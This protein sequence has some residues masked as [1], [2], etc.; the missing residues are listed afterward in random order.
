MAGLAEVMTKNLEAYRYYSLGVGKAQA[1]ENVEAV[2]LLRKAIQL[3]PKFAMAYARIGYAY[4]VTD[5]LPEKGRPFLEKALQLSDRLTE[6]DRLY[7]KAWHAIARQDYPDAIGTLRQII[8]QYP[9]ETEAHARLSRLLYRFEERA[10]DA[11]AVAQQGLAADPEAKDLYNVLGIYF[12]GLRRYDEA[13][14]AHQRYVQLAPAEPNAH[15]SLGMS[16]QQ[17]GRY[18]KAAAEYN[19][20]LSLDP[21]FEPAIIHLGDVY[22]QQGRY[23]EAVSQY[24]RYVQVTRSDAARAVGYG[25]IAQ[26][27]R[28]KREFRQGE[29][30]AQLE[31]NH[32]KRAIWNSLQFALDRGDTARAVNLKK[33]LF[34]NVPYPERGAKNELRSHDYY[35]GTLALRARQPDAA[36]GH[37]NQALHHLPPSSGLDLYDDCLANA[38]LELGRL[39]EAIA[40][41]QHILQFNPNY[42]LAE[43]HLGQAYERKGKAALARAAYERFLQNWKGADPDIPE[44]IE[45]K[46]LTTRLA[47]NDL[48]APDGRSR[49]DRALAARSLTSLR[50]STAGDGHP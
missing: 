14:A 44:V 42:P 5:F 46:S 39:E 38:Y 43:F 31:M 19:A 21:E 32:E 49:A 6:K 13:I 45:A 33:M 10:E 50:K 22:T 2:A 47:A 16:Y 28:R 23:R 24:Q 1:F 17:S 48:E 15:D 30:A 8:S 20:A 9:L 26:V 35:L 29:Q 12:L 37:F 7:V 3:D 4:S 36:I 40:E 11:I 41:Y 27:Y 25:S 34:Q 18:E